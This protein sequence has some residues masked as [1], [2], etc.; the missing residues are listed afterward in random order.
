MSLVY[1][2]G[3]CLILFNPRGYFSPLCLIKAASVR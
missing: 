2:G 1:F 3:S